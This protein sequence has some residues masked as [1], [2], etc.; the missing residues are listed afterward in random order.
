MSPYQPS[1]LD[2]TVQLTGPVA[3]GLSLEVRK[4]LGG[5]AVQIE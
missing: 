5:K 3:F 2:L 4:Q 1:P